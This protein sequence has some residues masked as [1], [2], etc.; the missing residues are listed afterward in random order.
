MPAPGVDV[1]PEEKGE[2]TMKYALAL[3]RFILVAAMVLLA[4]FLVG[5]ITLAGLAFFGGPR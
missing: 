5:F 4:C 3:P 1:D 2:A